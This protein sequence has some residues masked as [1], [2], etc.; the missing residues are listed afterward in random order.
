MSD[1]KESPAGQERVGVYVCH[2]GSNIAGTI[3]VDEV[4]KWIESNPN[5]VVSRHYEFMCSS[6]GQELI[7]KDIKEKGLTRVVVASCSPHMHEK[8]FREATERG[9]LNPFLFEMANIR[10]HGSW[11]TNNK[12]A[13]TLKAKALVNGAVERVVHHV[14]LEKIPVDINPN[15]LIV[16]GGIA[17]ITAALELAEAGHHVYL[18]EREGTIGGHMAQIDK[19]F[20]TL[21]C[22][23]C[24]LTPK[25]VDVGQNDN[26]TLLT[27]SEVESVEGYIGNFNITVRK[28]ARCV[29]EELCTSCG[30]CEEKCPQK[31]VDD[32]YGAGMGYRKAIYRAFPQA[33]PGYPVLDKENCTYF[34]TGKCKVCEKVCP[35]EAIAYEQEDKLINFDVGNIIL[36]TGYD[37]FD[38]R[39]IT[40]YGYGRLANVFSSLEFERMVNASGP[41]GGHIVLRDGVTE[42]ERIAIVHCVGSRDKNHNEYCSKVCCMYSLKFAHLVHEHL[43]GAEVYNYYIDMR[44]PGK[45]YEEFYHRLLNEG[46]HFI[47]GR[48]A[49]ISNA[50]AFPCEEGKL[51]VQAENTLLGIQQ[52]NPVDMVILSA[53]IE[54]RHD[55]EEV[56]KLFKM[57][58]DY[59]G[60]FNERHPKLAPVATMTDGVFIAGACQG[61]KDIPDTVAQG[62][63]A[64]SQVAKLISQGTVMMEPV[65]ASIRED[66]C[67]GCRICN[68]LCPYNA[69]E[70]DEEKGVSRVITALCQGCGTCVAACPS[71]VID[72]AHFTNTQVMA[73]L[74]GILWDVQAEAPIKQEVA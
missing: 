42:P 14:P 40:Q 57:G 20:P 23:A 74:S 54:A 55:A 21:D 41:T 63:A 47:R 22:S 6:T 1:I 72:G 17:G 12:E 7:E 8:T 73:E 10:E 13:A 33:V 16:G 29:N 70:F 65:R 45:G 43:P 53:G 44:T 34:Q 60:F 36:A 71:G 26:I 62:A 51:V 38:A 61:P 46:T 37:L 30:I 5:V 24:I 68:T 9:G 31:V 58:C 18:V 49:E 50:A 11:A 32:N 52:R 35:T 28:K 4:S 3:N 25:M 19:T 15:T 27:Y 2:C 48:V 66:E 67:S 59:D 39:K 64:A 69:I 56:S